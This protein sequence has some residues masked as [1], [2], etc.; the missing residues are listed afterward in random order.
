MCQILI[1]HVKAAVQNK[2]VAVDDATFAHHQHMCAGDGFL[3]IKADDVG[4]QIARADGNLL[5][6]KPVDGVDAL[7]DTP[8]PLEIELSGSLGHLVGKLA[9]EFPMVTRKETFDALDGLLILLDSDA[10]AAC[11]GSDANVAIEARA[12]IPV[13][14]HQWI[15]LH[16][17][18]QRAPISTGCGAYGH[19][20]TSDIDQAPCRTRVGIRA[21]ITRVATMLLARELDRRKSITLRQGYERVGLIIFEVSIEPRGVL[22]DEVLFENQ[23][24]VLACHDDVFEGGYL[25]HEQRDFRTLILKIHVLAHTRTQLLCLTNVNNLTRRIFPQINPRKRRYRVELALDARKLLFKRF[26]FRNALMQHAGVRFDKNVLWAH[27]S[28]LH[29]AIDPIAAIRRKARRDKSPIRIE[30]LK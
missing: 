7:F 8:R 19:D 5:V 18:I 6:G 24:L 21:E 15:R 14:Q 4:I 16:A 27:A 23:A 11:T 1:G 3:A 25:L 20:A 9:D 28:S 2:F 26:V 29:V 17:T 12:A 10:P 30:L 13:K 22:I